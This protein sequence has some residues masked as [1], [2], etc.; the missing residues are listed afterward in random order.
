MARCAVHEYRSHRW[1]PRDSDYFASLCMYSIRLVSR[2]ACSKITPIAKCD[3]LDHFKSMLL[4]LFEFLDHLR[5]NPTGMKH[6][7]N[8]LYLC[9]DMH[10]LLR[11]HPSLKPDLLQCVKALLALHTH[12]HRDM[13]PLDHSYRGRLQEHQL[14]LT[15]LCE[16]CDI[17]CP[18]VLPLLSRS[19]KQSPPE[20][21]PRSPYNLNPMSSHTSLYFEG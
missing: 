15:A 8:L 13:S 5:V 20:N 1:D 3:P 9:E 2:T 18:K 17:S 11:T 21:N 16:L 14:T 4:A 6:G 19:Y 10:G 12:P 7:N